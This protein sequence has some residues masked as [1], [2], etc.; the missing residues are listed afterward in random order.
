MPYPIRVR[1][2]GWMMST[3]IG[4]TLGLHRRI[5]NNLALI[6]PD[7]AET[8]VR[9]LCHAVTDN[10]GRTIIETYSHD[11]FSELCVDAPM[12][13]PGWEALKEAQRAK[14]PAVL[15]TGHFGNYA[16]ARVALRARGFSIGVLYRPFNNPFFE[17]RHRAAVDE[18]GPG[19][20]RGPIGLSQMVRHLKN[21]DVAAIVGD[22]HVSDGAPLRFF[23]MPAATATSAAR[24]AVKYEADLIPVY[25]VRQ[26][27]GLHFDLVF[28]PPVPVA[29]PEQMTQAL[30]DSLEQMVRKYPEQWMW[31][32]R[33]WKIAEGQAHNTDRA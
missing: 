7:L 21:G 10:M 32:H 8:E 14:R 11:E 29:S 12:A 23:G 4:P 28:E 27:D 9:R 15:F 6:M 33:R 24:L 22:Q 16:A 2:F 18:F 26:S 3:V 5:R 17:A 31:T 19:F 25:S 13:G 1:Y 30:N 20:A